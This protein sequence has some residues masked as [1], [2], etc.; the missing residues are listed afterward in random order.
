A[1]DVDVLK[2]GAFLDE[3]RV[4]TRGFV[5]RS[6]DDPDVRNLT[7]QVEV[8]ELEAVF[9][10]GGLQLGKPFPDLGHRQ[11]EL[12]AIT[13]R[14]LPPAAAACGQLDAHADLRTYADLL[15][16]F[17][18]QPE[19]GVLLDDRDDVPPHLEGQH[20]HLDELGVLESVADDGRV[21][22]GHRHHRQ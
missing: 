6:L 18:H 14:R 22:G 4:N 2:P 15:R 8:Q 1:T 16:V 10:A 17:K 5:E 19:F 9:H 11:P 13:S 7:A 20:G 3:F 21:V 12:R